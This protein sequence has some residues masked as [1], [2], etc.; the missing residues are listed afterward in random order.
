[1]YKN[2]AKRKKAPIWSFGNP[3]VPIIDILYLYELRYGGVEI[4]G[5][6]CHRRRLWQSF[7]FLL[8]LSLP[9]HIY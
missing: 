5:D 3:D 7:R 9:L 6:L 8:L 2:D 4:Q 1:M